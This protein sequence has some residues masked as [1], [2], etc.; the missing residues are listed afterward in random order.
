MNK[1]AI[2]YKPLR[3]IAKKRKLASSPKRQAILVLGMH[4]SGTSAV[5]GVISALG[6]GGPKTWAPPAVD[7]PRGH[8]ESAA[9]LVAHDEMLATA[10]SHWSDWRPVNPQWLHSKAAEQHRQHIKTIIIEEFGDEPLIFIKDPRICRLIPFISSILAELN[11]SPV[12]IIPVR[13]PLEVAYSLKHRN[14]FAVP[15]SS[16]LWLRHVLEAEFHSRHMPRTFLSYEKFLVDWR[17][18]VDRAAEETG[19]VWPDRSGRSDVRIDQFLTLDLRHERF[20]FDEIKDHPEV[21]PLVLE[22]YYILTN[23]VA[24]GENK[25]LLDRL[26]VVR[27]KFDEGCDMFGAAMVEEELAIKQ[28]RGELSTRS[29]QAEQFQRENLILATLSERRSVEAFRL[30]G[31]RDALVAAHNSLIAERNSLAAARNRLIAERDGL[32][33]ARNSLIAERDSLATAHDSLISERDA[34]ARDNNNLTAERDALIGAYSSLI[35]ER[36]SL[37]AAH[38]SLISERDALASVYSKL[39]SEH[40]ALA[41]NNNNLTAERDALVAAHNSLIGERDSLAA[42]HNS[43]ISERDALASVHSKLISEHRALARDYS[44]LT[45]ERDALTAACNSLIAERDAMLVSRSWRWTA[46]LRLLRKLFAR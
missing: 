27:T 10:G 9:L 43:L 18:H 14:E 8:F 13:N 7:N 39:I 44:N 29:A 38:N 6:V 20:S 19:V 5:G 4:R 34:L 35:A 45:A 24:N 23:I 32:A 22:T 17:H 41:R 31:E 12:A 15:R 3:S 16:L 25:K 21:T 26:D 1:T 40:R 36:D 33:A 30:T 11:V 28:L 42:A 46:P 2:R 37:A